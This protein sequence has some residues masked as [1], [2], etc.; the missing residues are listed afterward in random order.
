MKDMDA[1]SK[2]FT[3]LPEVFMDLVDFA[4]RD[5][6]FHVVRGSLKERNAET[7]ARLQGVR[8]WFKKVSNDIV[9]ELQVTDGDV[10]TKLLVALENQTCTSAVMAGRSLMSTAIRWDGWRRELKQLHKSRKELKSHQEVLDGVLPSDRMIP[11]MILVIHFGQEAWTGLP[12]F[13]DTLACPPPL[14]PMLADCPSNVISFYNLS[15]NELEKIQE[16]ATRAVAKSIRFVDDMD[17]LC[18]EMKKDQSFRKLLEE[19]PDEAL[20][21]ITIATGL[22]MQALKK[23]KEKDMVKKV[24]KFE[25]HFIN[26][27]KVLGKEEGRAEGREEGRAEGREEGREEERAKIAL[28]FIQNWRRRNIPES[29]I[30]QDLQADFELDAATA[31]Q[32][33]DAQP[34]NA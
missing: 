15:N 8:S 24:S 31:R 14:K 3:G 19:G 10:T 6:G 18:D 26:K 27:G 4:L 22:D 23:D 11:V 17:R 2:L 25:Q 29:Q 33:M 9:A 13:T 32:Y 20:D 1:A 28:K 34:A 16:G 21:V 30:L 5:T 7:I 12:R